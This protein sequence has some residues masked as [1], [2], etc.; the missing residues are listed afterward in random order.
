MQ[1]FYLCIYRINDIF[2]KK[3]YLFNLFYEKIRFICTA[4]AAEYLLQQAKRD[5]EECC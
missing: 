5:T 4:Y 3:E 2:V 1:H